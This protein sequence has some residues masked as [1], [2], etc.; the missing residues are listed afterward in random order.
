ME[1]SQYNMDR[2]WDTSKYYPQLSLSIFKVKV[3]RSTKGQTESLVRADMFLDQCFVKNAKIALNGPNRTKLESRKH[4]KIPRKCIKNGRF[5][6]SKYQNS[7]IFKIS[8][9]NFYAHIYLAGLFRI[10]SVLMNK[11]HRPPCQSRVKGSLKTCL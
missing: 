11:K 2:V 5:R 4:T 9:G 8:A 3:T 6:P 7:V 10:Y 1:I